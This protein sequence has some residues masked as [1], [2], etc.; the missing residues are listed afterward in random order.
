MADERQSKAGVDELDDAVIDSTDDEIEGVLP[1]TYSITSYGADYPVDGLIKRLGSEAIYVPEFQR[2]F[3]WK[4]PQASRFVES[5]LLGLPVPGIFL[6][7]DDDTQRL[8][9]IDGQQRLLTLKYFYD[10][11]FAETGR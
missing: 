6:A 1:F 7:K 8:L 9:V 4:L 5:L 3:V 11:V 10:G 2:G